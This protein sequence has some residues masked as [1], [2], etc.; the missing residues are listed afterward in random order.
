MLS[1]ICENLPKDLFG[2]DSSV[3][4]C[5]QGHIVRQPDVKIEPILNVFRKE[6]LLEVGSN[7]AANHQKYERT[8]Q[9]A[10]AMR[11][12][13]ADQPVVEVGKAS[14]SLLLNRE[15]FLFWGSLNVV[16]QEW[17]E[18]HGNDECAEQRSSHY[19]RKAS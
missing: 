11:D 14:L 18:R 5:G 19:D 8:E 3:V 7:E 1:S 16:T 10:P 6:L 17:N 15:L 13:A 4:R 12:R 9:D 2:F